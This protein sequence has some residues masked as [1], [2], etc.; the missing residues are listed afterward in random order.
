MSTNTKRSIFKQFSIR[1]AIVLALSCTLLAIAACSSS[2]SKSD[3]DENPNA[4]N[5]TVSF[6]IKADQSQQPSPS[7]S[8]ATGA[9]TLA[10]DTQSGALS[11]SLTMTDI[12]ATQAHIH[13]GFA[14]SDGGVIIELEIAENII[15]V[16]EGTVLD[17]AQMAAM[18]A[19][20]YYINIHSQGFPSGEIR[21]QISPDDVDIILTTL[22]GASEV[23]PVT[24]SAQG[25]AFVTINRTTGVIVINAITTGLTT[26]QSAHLHSAFAG[27]NGD[28]SVSL[29][30]SDSE[31][32]QFTS[33]NETVLEASALANLM[34]GGSYVNVHSAENLSG[35]LRGQ[36]LPDGVSVLSSIL[37]G[38]QEVP[39][40]ASIATGRGFVTL[41]ENDASLMAIVSTTGVDDATAA[42]IHEAAAGVNGGIMF[43]LEQD[44]SAAG[45]W[46]AAITGVTDAQVSTLKAAGS[47]FNVHTPAN[48]GGEIRGQIEP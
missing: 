23:P 26:P 22:S 48:G 14:G 20:S 12:T 9:G 28:V 16:P 39:A 38:D 40:V 44:S 46:S 37:S 8:S 21:A 30:Q 45:I 29:V 17:T 43:P 3:D 24:S 41:N 10:L 25:T 32:G 18:N 47:Y 11:G 27:S 4:Q 13:E 15:S 1:T 36:V 33:A 6:V 34:S 7:G 42:H 35:E 5:N 31:V 19:G 2:D